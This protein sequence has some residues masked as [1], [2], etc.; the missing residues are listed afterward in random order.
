MVFAIWLPLLIG[1]SALSGALKPD[2]HTDFTQPDSESKQ[3]QDAFAAAGDETADG[4]PAQIVFTAPQGIEDA[5]VKAA[6][7]SFFAEVAEMPG[8]R[9]TSPYDEFGAAQISA[10][11]P[12]AFADLSVGNRTQTEFM[13]ARRRHQGARRPG[14]RPRSD[15]RVRRSDLPS[16]QLPRE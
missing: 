12:I 6:M 5:A 13:A 15:H 4:I 1:L 10:T 16:D 3:V 11:E 8:V 2:Y 14:R 9:V 7:S